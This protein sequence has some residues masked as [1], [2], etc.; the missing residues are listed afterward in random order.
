MSHEKVPVIFGGTRIGNRELFKPENGLETFLDILSPH[1]AETIDT[2]Q[3]Y[4]DSEA[5]IGQVRAGDR[6]NIDTKWSP[7]CGD[8]S[9][10]WATQNRITNSA[11]ESIIDQTQ[12]HILQRPST[13]FIAYTNV[14]YSGASESLA[15]E[16]EAIHSYCAEHGYSLPKVYQGSYNPFNRYK[17]SSLLPT[18]RKLGMS[19]YTYGPSAVG[20]LAKTIAQAETMA[21]DPARVS[22]TCRPYLG[23][24]KYADALARWSAVA[25][26]EGGDAMILGASSPK[27]LEETLSGI[28]KGPLSGAACAKIDEIWECIKPSP[29]R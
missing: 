15:S 17:E 13:P 18:L 5:T 29:G 6:F 22:A 11:Q 2:A 16:V 21:R 3:S 8:P 9:E 20:F 28:E 10:P 24:I 4:G 19:F 1:G 27:R 12:I 14:A 7:Y 26:G 25:D 23:S